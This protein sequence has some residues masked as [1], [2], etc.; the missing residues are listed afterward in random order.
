MSDRRSRK[1]RTTR[2]KGSR[3]GGVSK[4]IELLHVLLFF[5]ALFMTISLISYDAYE[6]PESD[7]AGRSTGWLGMVGNIVAYRLSYLTF[8]NFGA[9]AIPLILIL[10]LAGWWSGGKFNPLRWIFG[11]I[12]VGFFIGFGTAYFRSLHEMNIAADQTGLIPLKLLELSNHYLQPL[13]TALVALAI[14][15]ALA[16]LLVNLK[17]VA[18]LSTVFY[19]IPLFI[20]RGL[21]SAITR[22]ASSTKRTSQKKIEASKS[23]IPE[24]ESRP[25]HG[26][27]LPLEPAGDSNSN[28]DLSYSEITTRMGNAVGMTRGDRKLPPV[29]LLNEPDPNQ[30]VIDPAELDENAERLE[31]KLKNLGITA[32]VLKTVPGPVITR[33]DLEPAAE[34]KV[35]RIANLTDDIAMALRARGVRILAPIPGESAVG[36]EIPNRTPAT[37]YMR[38][39]IDSEEFRHNASPLSIALGK[40]ASGKIFCTDLTSLPHLLIAGAT[41]SGKSVCINVII[42]SLLYRSDPENV[43]LVLIDPKKLELSL[44]ARLR[45]HHLAAPPG[46]GEDVITTPENAVKTLQSIHLEME[47]RYEI[48]AEAGVR[49]LSE[50]RHWIES[51]PPPVPEEETRERLPYIVVIIDELADLMMVLRR[52]FE[53]LVARLAQMSRAVGIHLVV[54]TQRPSVDVVT[55]LIKA[56]FPARIAFQVATRVDSRT[57]ID[58]IGAESLLGKGDMICQG[59]GGLRSGRLHGALITTEEV[60]R[61]VEF[62]RAQPP[63]ESSFMLPDPEAARVKVGGDTDISVDGISTDEF[64]NEAAKIVVRTEQGSISVLQRRLR[65]GYAR[66]ARLIDELEQAGIVGPFD[67]SKARQVLITPEELHERYGID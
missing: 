50:Y 13:G 9:F 63:C 60:E 35:A 59:L 16:V 37:V 43:R 38:D 8:G 40:D 61:I 11:V 14:I 44:Y 22:K 31:D 34:V 56:N 45:D 29:D 58:G 1:N 18:I 21:S 10:L 42:A 47:R 54:A 20:I 32:K 23:T 6:S 24:M 36:I 30:P 12:S 5:A 52:E 2:S 7:S 25:E 55:G 51:T 3:S 19:D 15:I 65:V 48:L 57:I 46:L 67:G 33:Y 64:F 53:D 28:K 39:V 41:G 27:R 4:A 62:V 17:P 26:A 66:A 49:G